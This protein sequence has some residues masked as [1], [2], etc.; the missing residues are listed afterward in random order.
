MQITLFNFNGF[1]VR[2]VTRPNGEPG[3]VG[4]DVADRLGYADTVNAIKQHCRGVAIH[5]PIQDALGR[6]QQARILTEPDV[7]RLIVSS[8]LPEAE[9]FER[10]VFEEVLPSIR[11]T[12]AYAAPAAAPQAMP[13][14][15]EAM[16][17]ADALATMLRLEGSARLG[18]A[19]KA[20]ELTAP[21][22]LPM[23]P[24]Y[25]IDAPTGSASGSSEPTASLTELLKEHGI[26][27]SAVATNAL[28]AASGL[29][30]RMERPSTRGAK[31]YWSVTDAGMKY[32]KNVSSDRNQRETQPH[33]YRARFRELM[34]LIKAS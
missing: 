7:M 13:S 23:V 4:K 2:A 17:V 34:G 28:L 6:A 31:A 27:M 30:V 18:V 1:T 11:R 14:S 15:V 32:G 25:A 5:H 20:M 24:A 8:K 21:S 16:Q 22:L 9:A 3:F 10:W 33:W 29:I 26:K 12:G 19:R